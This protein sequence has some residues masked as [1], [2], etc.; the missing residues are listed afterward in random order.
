RYGTV[1]D[2]TGAV[3]RFRTRREA[4]QAAND[5]EARVRARTWR[6][7]AAGRITFGEYVNRWYAVQDLAVSTMQNYRRSI[8]DHLLPAFESWALADIG[9][10]DVAAWEKRERAAGY[11][12]SSVRTWRAILHLILADAV[13]EGRIPSNPA[14]R[15]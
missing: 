8:E 3:I 12:D 7:P 6:D 14:T 2:P 11:A 5:E 4:E 15:R 10:S 13:E 9:R 1:R